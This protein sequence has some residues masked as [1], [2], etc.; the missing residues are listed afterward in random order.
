MYPWGQ[1]RHNGGAGFPLCLVHALIPVGSMSPSWHEGIRRQAM[2]LTLQDLTQ[3]GMR[4]IRDDLKY[5]IQAKTK[6]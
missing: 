2:C 6:S 5:K 1:I 4:N 3:T